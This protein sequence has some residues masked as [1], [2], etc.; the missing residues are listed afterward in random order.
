M[1]I[2]KDL[3]SHELYTL[4]PTA[5]VQQARELMLKQ[6]IRHIPIVNEDDELLGLVS[7]RDVLAAS[8]STLADLQESERNEIE[9][10]IP[11]SKI[12]LNEV[13]IAK[14]N[15]HLLEAAR[16]MLENQQGC[17]PV[18]NES[19]LVGILTEADFVRLSLF[20]LKKMAEYENTNH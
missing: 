4:K 15:T 18:T 5:T 13:V 19:K 17:L 6:H 7:K 8:V 16:F 11:I 3:M 1:L 20:L 12:M 9:S 2:V 14:E 10:H